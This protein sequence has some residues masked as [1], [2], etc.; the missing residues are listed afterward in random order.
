MSLPLPRPVGI[1]TQADVLVVSLTREVACEE[2]LRQLGAQMPGGVVLRDAWTLQSSRPI[3]PETA[4]YAVDLSDAEI[5]AV[6]EHLSRLLAAESWPVQRGA[7][8][9]GPAKLLDLRA[10]LAG[11]ELDRHTLSWTVRFGDGGSVR[12]GE[13]LT[14]MGIDPDKWLHRVSRTAIAWRT[15]PTGAPEPD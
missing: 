11:A 12:P 3:Q 5:P 2:V 9:S 4:S 10:Q 14:A 6:N 15:E 8:Q 7:A 13:V 1:A